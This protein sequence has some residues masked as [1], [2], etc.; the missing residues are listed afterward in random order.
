MEAV[1]HVAGRDHAVD[2]VVHLAAEGALEIL[3]ACVVRQAAEVETHALA[4]Q[5]TDPVVERQLQRLDHVEH[6]GVAPAEVVALGRQLDAADYRVVHRVVVGNAL[7]LEGGDD[8]LVVE[9]LGHARA[10]ADDPAAFPHEVLRGLCG[11]PRR[12]VGLGKPELGLGAQEEVGELVRR[13]FPLQ[14]ALQREAAYGN[15]EADGEAREI[16]GGS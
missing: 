5:E 10:H 13:V 14:G 15:V 6:G 7:G 8:A 1:H 2:E 12:E 9:D 3:E 16:L 4:A 11:E